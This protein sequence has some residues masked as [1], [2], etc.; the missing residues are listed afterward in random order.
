MLKFFLTPIAQFL[1]TVAYALVLTF[2]LLIVGFT[3][4]EVLDLGAAASGPHSLN[5]T[6]VSLACWA[7][8]LALP[9]WA[10]VLIVKKLGKRVGD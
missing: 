7:V 2:V 10:A 6:I 8:L 3:G 9:A 4:G 5:G 1:A